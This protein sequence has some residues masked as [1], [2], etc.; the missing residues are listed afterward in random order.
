MERLTKG[1]WK[2]EIHYGA[3]LAPPKENL[4][5]IKGGVFQAAGFCAAY[6]PGKV[7]L[8]T[9]LELP[10]LAPEKT[11]DIGKLL[12]ALWEHPALLKELR[13]RWN[14]VP[15]LPGQLL[16][17]HLMGNKPV[18]TVEDF[19]GLRV[20]IG[21]EIAK[22]L[23]EFGAVPTLVPAPEVYTAVERGTIDVV[24]FPWTYAYG[25]YKIHEVSKYA[26]VGLS[27]GTMNCPYVANKDAWE[28][29]P[30]EW[31]GLHQW[32]YEKAVS[33]W[34]AEYAKADA[35]WLPIFAERLEF[36]TFPPEERA[37]LVAKAEGVWN[38]WAEAREKEGLPG[39]EVLAYT[40]AKKKEILGK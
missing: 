16:Q 9:V 26:N 34:A 39:K 35:H 6:H 36:I 31:K 22:V 29:L 10:F 20:R 19:K 17:Y 37:K 2:I 40:L 12:V 24:G 18:R 13:E 4:D 14:A 23:K 5:G 32:W 3:A 15:L 11:A 7:P 33:E 25:A 38:A 28:A 27:L 21:G 8:H 1:L 30:K